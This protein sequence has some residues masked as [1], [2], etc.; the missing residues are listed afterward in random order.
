MKVAI[1]YD[2]ILVSNY[3]GCKGKAISLVQNYTAKYFQNC[4]AITFRKIIN[5]AKYKVIFI[6]FD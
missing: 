1:L 5:H 2:V 4:K 6:F 3:Y